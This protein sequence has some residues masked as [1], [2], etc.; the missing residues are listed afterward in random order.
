MHASGSP[1]AQDLMVFSPD[2]SLINF[3]ETVASPAHSLTGHEVHSETQPLQYH[4][5]R[6]SSPL[7]GVS[8]AEAVPLLRN[9]SEDVPSAESSVTERDPSPF[10]CIS[11]PAATAQ[12][13]NEEQTAQ[14]SK[15][16]RFDLGAQRANSPPSDSGSEDPLAPNATL[17]KNLLSN[18]TRNITAA[19]ED[20]P[21]VTAKTTKTSR[22]KSAA[23]PKP[24]SGK[25]ATAVKSSTGKP[26]GVLA[27]FK[28]GRLNSDFD[29]EDQMSLPLQP[30]TPV[31][32]S[33]DTEAT[34]DL[35]ERAIASLVEAAIDGAATGTR[36]SGRAR[37]PKDF[38]DVEVHGWKS[39]RARRS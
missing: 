13:V 10:V 8:N 4:T 30:Q 2:R 12:T 1:Q 31:S 17:R 34:V 20:S 21:L 14:M 23:A 37:K 32:D 18:K 19:S 5:T 3:D 9:S 22:R 28:D 7:P 24:S 39:K 16:V 27:Q 29:D 36:R 25:T 26:A 15:R 33:Q 6:L 38:G 35:A 11:P